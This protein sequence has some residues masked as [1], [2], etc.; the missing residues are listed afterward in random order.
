MHGINGYQNKD[1]DWYN[2]ITFN[3][4]PGQDS[5]RTSGGNTIPANSNELGVNPG[6]LEGWFSLP[7]PL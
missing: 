7:L 4:T 1:V 5:I 6:F 2:N 3:G